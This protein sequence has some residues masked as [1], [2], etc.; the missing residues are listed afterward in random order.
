[1]KYN[2]G[3]STLNIVFKRYKKRTNR[4]CFMICSYENEF[5]LTDPGPKLVKIN[6]FQIFWQYTCSVWQT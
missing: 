2:H 6:S 1:M 4:I 5:D 3:H